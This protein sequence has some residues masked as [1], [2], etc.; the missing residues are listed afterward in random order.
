MLKYPPLIFQIFLGYFGS[1]GCDVVA[2]SIGN[3][4]LV[5]MY[6]VIDYAFRR[7]AW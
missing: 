4:L 7:N 2:R 1:D 6:R 3:E 5:A